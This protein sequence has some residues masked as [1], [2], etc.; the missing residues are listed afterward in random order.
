[1]SKLNCMQTNGWLNVPAVNW[2]CVKWVDWSALNVNTLEQHLHWVLT[3][4]FWCLVD[5]ERDHPTAVINLLHTSLQLNAKRCKKLQTN[6][7][8]MT[9]WQ[10]TR[11]L[12]TELFSNFKIKDESLA[13]RLHANTL[14]KQCKSLDWRPLISKWNICVRIMMI[15][16]IKRKQFHHTLAC[17]QSVSH[18]AGANYLL[19]AQPNHPVSHESHPRQANPDTPRRTF[20]QKGKSQDHKLDL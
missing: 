12:E 3:L 14:S 7:Q 2:R 9:Q 13:G 20:A 1:M 16:T 6:F 8:R 18:I 10:V 5:G 11:A 17:K 4:L 15:Q 19:G